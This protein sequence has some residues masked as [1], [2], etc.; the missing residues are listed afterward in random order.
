MGAVALA[1]A[2]PSVPG[3]FGI[4]EQ[5]AHRDSLGT[6]SEIRPGEIQRMSAG[7]GIAH[8]EYNASR[9]EAVHLL[10]IWV[11]PAHSGL[12]PS[13]EQ[14][15]FDERGAH[16]AFLP[17]VVPRGSETNGS[18]VSVDQNVTVS[19]ARLDTDKK[20]TLNLAE[21]RKAWVQLA[22][23]ALSVN[24]EHLT[25]GDGAAVSDESTLQFAATEPS[26]VLFFD[27]P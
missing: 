9:E 22:K 2:A 4:I 24:G 17:I 20:V 5:L 13:Y 16:N 23:G 27:L 1:V 25:A 18:G 21:G 26:E 6:G 14:K 11:L 8:S 12:E 19:V 7:T 3:F 10:Q 15:R